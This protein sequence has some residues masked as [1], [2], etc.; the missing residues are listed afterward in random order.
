MSGQ[1]KFK[2][3]QTAENDNTNLVKF[4]INKSN[5]VSITN[6]E[7]LMITTIDR[8][9]DIVNIILDNDLSQINIVWML[10]NMYV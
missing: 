9:L 2:I 1:Y 8:F 10:N 5:S 6:T 7:G 4:F 3:L